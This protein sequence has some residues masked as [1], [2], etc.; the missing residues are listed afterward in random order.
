[1]AHSYSHLFNLRTTGLRFFTVYTVDRPD[2]A[3]QTFS[4]AMVSG[5]SIKVFNNET[6]ERFYV[7]R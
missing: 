6:I 7:Y 3:L 4:R 2:M 1:M 5:K